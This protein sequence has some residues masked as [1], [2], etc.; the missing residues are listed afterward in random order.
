M[1]KKRRLTRW[2]RSIIA[3][4]FSKRNLIVKIRFLLIIYPIKD[5]LRVAKGPDDGAEPVTGEQEDVEDGHHGEEIRR[6]P[7]QVA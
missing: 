2:L 7:H 1:P 4:S 6:A 3:F 5:T